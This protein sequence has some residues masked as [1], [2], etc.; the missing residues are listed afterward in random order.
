MHER[1]DN[2]IKKENLKAAVELIIKLIYVGQ[3]LM[4]RHVNYLHIKQ[5]SVFA[6]SSHGQIKISIG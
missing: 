3:N 2:F 5:V 4:S 1:I 6:V